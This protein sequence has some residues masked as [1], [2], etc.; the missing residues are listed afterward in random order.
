MWK[1]ESALVPVD[2]TPHGKAALAVARSL[3]NDASQTHLLHVLRDLEP[4][5]RAVLFPYAPLGEDEPA[6]LDELRRNGARHIIESLSLKD[7]QTEMLDVVFGNEPERILEASTRRGV[8]ILICSSHGDGGARM[9]L[10]SV[11]ARILGSATVP[12]W[13]SRSFGS[14]G[15]V[16]SILVAT[17][18]TD[19][20]SEVLDAACAL[21]MKLEAT[22]EVLTVIPDPLAQDDLGLL[23]SSLRVDKKQIATKSKERIDA[24]YERTLQKLRPAHPEKEK[25]AELLSR[26]R[27][28]MGRPHE[29]IIRRAE[30]F[31]LVVIGRQSPGSGVM[32]CGSVAHAVARGV[33]SDV[34]MV[35][36]DPN[37]TQEDELM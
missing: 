2:G 35:P 25:I 20:A 27:I 18:L 21:A 8:D 29:E 14:K 11:T 37:P 24:L 36:V 26:R 22:L 3:V 23:K 32:R 15:R 13:I 17:D 28:V 19:A 31:D 5:V 6:I 7:A 16:E 1:I 12:V 34:L 10:G 4:H 30:G 9:D 33:S